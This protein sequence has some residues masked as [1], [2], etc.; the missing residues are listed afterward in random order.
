MYKRQD[1][2]RAAITSFLA[3]Q[4]S[5]MQVTKRHVREAVAAAIPNADLTSKKALINRMIDELLS[6]G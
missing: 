6:G 4:P 1:Q 2:I 5:L 3:A